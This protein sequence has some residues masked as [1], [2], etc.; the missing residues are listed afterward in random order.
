MTIKQASQEAQIAKEK[1]S[2]FRN[3]YTNAESSSGWKG[4]ISAAFR[5]MNRRV[6]NRVSGV[7]SKYSGVSSK[8]SNLENTARRADADEARK[9]ARI[10]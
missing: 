6:M 5:N 3:I 1:I 9:A 7:T 4:D 10:R 8:L 2:N